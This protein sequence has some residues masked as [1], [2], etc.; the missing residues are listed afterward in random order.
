MLG[1]APQ[2]KMEYTISLH[3][4]YTL[5]SNLECSFLTILLLIMLSLAFIEFWPIRHHY[6]IGYFCYENYQTIQTNN[7]LPYDCGNRILSPTVMQPIV[8]YFKVAIYRTK[9]RGVNNPVTCVLSIA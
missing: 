1:L 7:V 5:V 4:F 9:T 8:I 2:S 6:T 3:H